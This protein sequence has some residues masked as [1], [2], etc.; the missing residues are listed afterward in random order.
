[1]A[2]TMANMA[3]PLATSGADM[4]LRVARLSRSTVSAEAPSLCSRLQ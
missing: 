2:G 1:V 4:A 3:S